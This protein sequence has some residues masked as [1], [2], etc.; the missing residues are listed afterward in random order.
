MGILDKVQR[1]EKRLEKL[2]ER[3]DVPLQPIEIRKAALDELEDLVEPAGRSR[4]AFPY[5]RVTVEVMA[6]DARQRAAMDAVLGENSDLTAAIADRL[7]SAGCQQP[8]GLDVRLKL[9]KRAGTEWETGRVFRVV[10][11]RVDA[12][13]RAADMPAATPR[14]AQLVVVKGET[15][16]KTYSLGGERTNI[17]RLAEVLDKDKRVVRRNHVVFTERESGINVTVSRAHA[18]IAATPAGEYRLF[19]DHS[20]YGTRILRAGRTLAL[21]AGSPRGTKL[22]PGDEIY[23]GQACVR[24]EMP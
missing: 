18:H 20:S 21:P 1:L 14:T 4:R 17:G 8:R 9:L 2:A 13:P 11:E 23:L 5:N 10:C 12:E 3:S 19:D 22:Q 16:R 24:F 15:R 7:K 6:T